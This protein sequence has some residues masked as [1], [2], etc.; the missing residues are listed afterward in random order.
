MKAKTANKLIIR[1]RRERTC[2]PNL[3]EYLGIFASFFAI[4]SE[5]CTD[6]L[7]VTNMSRLFHFYGLSPDGHIYKVYLDS[8]RFVDTTRFMDDV[9]PLTVREI[10]YEN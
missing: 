10:S 1:L 5:Y 9:G 2:A 7:H 4:G 8:L 3:K 6:P